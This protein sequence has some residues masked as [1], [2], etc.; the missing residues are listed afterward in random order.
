ALLPAKNLVNHYFKEDKTKAFFYGCAAHSTLPMTNW[1]SSS[2]GLV[3]LSVAHK[4]GW[5]F[6]KG[7]A[8]ALIRAL[9]SYYESLG[10]KIH[11]NFPVTHVNELPLS[12]AYL[13]DVTPRQL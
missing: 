1:A 9:V 2:F 5:P 13:F 8:A 10:G 11:L 3:L 12:K 4:Y 7:G 6:P